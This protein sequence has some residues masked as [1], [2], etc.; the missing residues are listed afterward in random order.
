MTPH[1]V[2]LLLLFAVLVLL[3]PAACGDDDARSGDP[4]GADTSEQDTTGA[5][6]PGE[7]GDDEGAADPGE[8][9]GD[10]AEDAGGD[11]GR[12]EGGGPAVCEGI[13]LPPPP[14]PIP[15]ELKRFAVNTYHFN[16][17][18][19]AGGLKGWMPEN[20]ILDLDD[21]EVQD[22]IVTESFEPLLDMYLDHP[23]WGADMELQGLMLDVMRERHP[24]AL[25]K[26][27][28]LAARGQVAVQSWH[29]SD[30][31]WVAYPTAA[32]E[33]SFARNVRSFEEA[34]IPWAP[35]AFTQEGQFS[36]S[37][38]EFGLPR[39][40][41]AAML[42]KNLLRHFHGEEAFVPAYSLGELAV[43][44]AGKSG[45]DEESGIELRWTFMD[46]GELALTGDLNP[47]LGLGFAYKPETRTELEAKLQ[48]LEDEGYRHVRV[49]DYVRTLRERGLALPE[50]PPVPDGTWQP[51][52][53]LNVARWMGVRGAMRQFEDDNAVLTTQRKLLHRLVAAG[54]LLSD[55]DPEGEKE[56]WSDSLG[57]AWEHA[58]LG[59]VSD[60]TGWNP[61][62]NE[63]SYS[64]DNAA[65]GEELL[66][67]LFTAVLT[68]QGWNTV[69][70][71]PAGEPG[72]RA[73]ADVYP[74]PPPEPVPADALEGVV[75]EA[76]DFVV[77]TTWT[78][79][80]EDRPIR[81]LE[82][83]FTP[84]EDTV[85]REQSVSFPLTTDK[86]S[87]SPALTTDVLREVP[88]AELEPEKTLVCLP[89]ANGLTRIGP[90][91]FVVAHQATVQ[92]AACFDLVENTLRFDDET[93]PVDAERAW[94][95]DL[96]E[97]DDVEAAIGHAGRVNVHP[98]WL[99]GKRE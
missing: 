1:P 95:F 28:T 70:V 51:H 9:E 25:E 90:S 81:R 37:M 78:K 13:D 29:W 59:Q 69:L 39:G 65:A 77:E 26:L 31:L 50:L 7:A 79:P 4:V 68:D 91:L 93:P 84:K 47:Y 61:I 76:A 66:D 75:A 45:K 11:A 20:P 12:D 82:V 10:A 98:M 52:N 92:L 38:K 8:A 97:S 74:E 32:M 86:L 35:V 44:V 96:Y 19:V 55:V 2:R 42:P 67:E 60:A 40:L 46:D 17:Q 85:T 63:V 62:G 73:M 88:L 49:V 89:Q 34:C 36:E 64:L 41:E 72:K 33:A 14:E 23:S 94:T 43:V 15:A 58:L 80:H 87:W 83:R 57:Q 22:R 24:A 21:A 16:V 18:Y 27:R 6:D 48:A 53:T 99:E 3:L 71:D 5:T 54:A 30:Q 56:Q